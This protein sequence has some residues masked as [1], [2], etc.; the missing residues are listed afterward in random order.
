[1]RFGKMVFDMA[2]FFLYPDP[3][4]YTF[5]Q[6]SSW[7]LVKFIDVY[8]DRILKMRTNTYLSYKDSTPAPATLRRTL[9]PAPPVDVLTTAENKCRRDKPNNALGPS[10]AIICL[11]ASNQ[12][13]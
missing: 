3:A 5:P 9:A 2:Y 13:L 12:D 7:N 1:M 4:V 10:L 11:P 8:Y 6:A